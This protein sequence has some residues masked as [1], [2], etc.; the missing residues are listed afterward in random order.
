MDISAATQ[1]IFCA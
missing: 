1:M